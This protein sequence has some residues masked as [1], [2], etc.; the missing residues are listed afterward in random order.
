MVD[1]L[2]KCLPL[3]SV[4]MITDCPDMTSAVYYGRYLSSGFH[5]A[6]LAGCTEEG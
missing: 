1:D 2:S 5:K 4:V 6:G 3:K